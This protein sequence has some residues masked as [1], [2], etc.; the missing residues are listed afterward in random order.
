MFDLSSAF[1]WCERWAAS[2]GQAAR[3]G[4]AGRR[5]SVIGGHWSLVTPGRTPSV[6]TRLNGRGCPLPIGRRRIRLAADWWTD[7]S[8]G[9]LMS[10][11]P[12]RRLGSGCGAGRRPRRVWWQRGCQPVIDDAARIVSL[13][14]GGAPCNHR[15]RASHTAGGRTLPSSCEFLMRSRIPIVGQPTAPCPTPDDGFVTSRQTR[16][17]SR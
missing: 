9:I 14:C 13:P 7:A 15:R 3:V 4:G 5:L 8:G 2:R 12:T 6:R 16:C 10:G 11:A 1:E 17:V